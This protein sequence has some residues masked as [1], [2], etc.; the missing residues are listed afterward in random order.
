MC[1]TSS[2][3]AALYRA[4]GGGTPCLILYLLYPCSLVLGVCTCGG[5]WEYGTA[6]QW[7]LPSVGP[8]WEGRVGTISTQGT[9]RP[10]DITSVTLYLITATLTKPRWVWLLC[11]CINY[12]KLLLCAYVCMLCICMCTCVCVHV[13]MCTCVCVHVY[14]YMCMHV[15]VY[16][17][18][19]TCTCVHVH[20]YVCMCMCTC[21]C[22]HVY[23]YMCMC[24]CV[25]LCDVCVHG[26]TM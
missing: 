7:R 3:V 19:C 9:W 12:T 14:V 24:T 8:Y 13:N 5:S 16:V 10:W 4:N 18:M 6:T 2:S 11:T 1:C 25:F 21:V 26:F 22:V 15:H 17:Y 23:V 20:V